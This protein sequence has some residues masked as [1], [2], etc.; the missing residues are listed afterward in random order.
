[1]SGTC[2]FISNLF[3]LSRSFFCHQVHGVRLEKL[4]QEDHGGLLVQRAREVQEDL[5]VQR[6]VRVS[7]EK[8]DQPDQQGHLDHQEKAV[9]DESVFLDHTSLQVH[10]CVTA[11]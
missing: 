2:C 1:M 5:L 6:E 4:E 11:V 8:M 7:L 3:F 10:V 9:Y